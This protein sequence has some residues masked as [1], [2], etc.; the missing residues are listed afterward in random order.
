MDIT[1]LVTLTC[2]NY[3][4]K[5]HRKYYQKKCRTNDDSIL[6]STELNKHLMLNKHFLL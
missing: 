6:S 3:Q 5:N 2:Y 1:G 4:K